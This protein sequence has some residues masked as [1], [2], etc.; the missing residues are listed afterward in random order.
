ML[1]YMTAHISLAY[2]LWPCPL[3]SLIACDC[4]VARSAAP[5][6]IFPSAS[7]LASPSLILFLLSQLLCPLRSVVLQ[8][9]RAPLFSARG[10]LL[11]T[12]DIGGM[13][14]WLRTGMYLCVCVC[15][16]VLGCVRG[17]GLTIQQETITCSSAW[18]NGDHIVSWHHFTQSAVCSQEKTVYECA[19]RCVILWTLIPGD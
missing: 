16:S 18:S 19:W 11:S 2:D 14:T 3:S 15:G 5:F 9:P 6:P 8:G 17:V 10:A 12:C 1:P 13:C 4:A 7:L